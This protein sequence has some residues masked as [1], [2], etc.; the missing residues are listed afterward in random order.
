MSG[1]CREPK[2]IQKRTFKKRRLKQALFEEK[3]EH[4]PT[5]RTG[6]EKKYLEQQNEQYPK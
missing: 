4:N 6:K 5:D 3:G 1:K 2:T